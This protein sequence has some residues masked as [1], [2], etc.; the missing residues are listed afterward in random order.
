VEALLQSDTNKSAYVAPAIV[1]SNAFERYAL[2]CSGAAPFPPPGATD[3]CAE[4]IKYGSS[5]SCN[6]CVIEGS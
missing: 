3:T 4:G 5:N 1:S 2:A 6:N